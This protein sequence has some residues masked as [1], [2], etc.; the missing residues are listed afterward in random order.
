M[1]KS[2][3]LSFDTNRHVKVQTISTLLGI[4]AIAF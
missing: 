1:I 2:A 3:T 4:I